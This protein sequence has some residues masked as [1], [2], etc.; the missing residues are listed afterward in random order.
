MHLG[1]N[2]SLKCFGVLDN[3]D[4]WVIQGLRSGDKLTIEHKGTWRKAA[5]YYDGCQWYIE[6]RDTN[7]YRYNLIG[8]SLEGLVVK[9]DY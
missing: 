3:L 1:Y 7:N 8:S 2:D 4:L 6:Y 9:L 5:I